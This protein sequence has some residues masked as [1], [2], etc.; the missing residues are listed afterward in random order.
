MHMFLLHFHGVGYE[1]HQ[2]M[3]LYREHSRH[4]RLCS[5]VFHHVRGTFLRQV[6]RTAQYPGQAF[7]MMT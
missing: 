2:G 5:C 7:S 1:Y 4:D 6:D 3:V